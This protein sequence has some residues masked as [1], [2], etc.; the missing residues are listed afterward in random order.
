MAGWIDSDR[1]CR[2]LVEFDYYDGPR[3]GIV[4]QDGDVWYFQSTF[5]DI[6]SRG[7]DIFLVWS[8]TREALDLERESWRIF[9]GWN[10]Q[11]EAGLVG[12][13]THPGL[14]G[15]NERF[16]EIERVLVAMRKP[17]PDAARAAV[18]FRWSDG[19]KRYTID[20]LDYYAKAQSRK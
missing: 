11:Y 19:Q 6:V 15:L 2:V 1:W 9:V 8:A 18:D 4:E 7:E 10:D 3:G 14:H 16:D 20:G 13:D 17:P 5:E 12:T